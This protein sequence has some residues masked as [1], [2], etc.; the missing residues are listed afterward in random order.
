M[1]PHAFYLAG[2]KPSQAL[3]LDISQVSS[4]DELQK[5]V[6]AQFGIVVPEEVGFQ[7][8]S[9]ELEDLADLEHTTGDIKVTVSGKA[10]RDVSGPEGLPF[11]GSYYQG[12]PR[13]LSILI[14]IVLTP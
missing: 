6:A 7:D 12:P 4:I 14:K 2:G 1:A 3:E 10:V 5:A 13:T 9:K 11:V 8:D